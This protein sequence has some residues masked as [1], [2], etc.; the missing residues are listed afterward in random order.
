MDADPQRQQQGQSAED[1]SLWAELGL[2]EPERLDAGPPVDWELLRRLARQ[3]L[4][5][6]A[7]RIVYGLIH[8]Y[9]GWNDAHAKILVEE[10]KARRGDDRA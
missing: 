10:F 8:R 9:R 7:T 3:E 1:F 6:Q 2:P 5:E 4:P